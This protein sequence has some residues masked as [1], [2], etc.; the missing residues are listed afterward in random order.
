MDLAKLQEALGFDV[1]EREHALKAIWDA[2]ALEN[3]A[4]FSQQL[5]V[6]LT[7]TAAPKKASVVTTI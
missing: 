2:L 5:I 6:T 1:V 3:E 4:R 7:P